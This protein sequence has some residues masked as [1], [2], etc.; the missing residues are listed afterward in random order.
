MG[1]GA[2][3]HAAATSDVVLG[4]AAWDGAL[5]SMRCGPASTSCSSAWR[6]SACVSGSGSALEHSRVRGLG[7]GVRG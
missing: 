4:P 6:D 5:S 2:G 1:T 3:G 7:L